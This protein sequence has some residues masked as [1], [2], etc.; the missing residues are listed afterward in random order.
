[1]S[2][3]WS[4]R[5]TAFVV[6]LV[7]TLPALL[8]GSLFG[9]AVQDGKFK[10]VLAAPDRSI[11][12]N[13]SGVSQR[14]MFTVCQSAGEVKLTTPTFVGYVSA[15][16]CLTFSESLNSGQALNVHLQS[17]TSASGTYSVSVLP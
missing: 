10:V 11:Y 14:V 6:C 17:G 16:E 4:R 15:P 1:M 8:P 2:T 5:M 13:G 7:L 9:Q 12:F 3:T